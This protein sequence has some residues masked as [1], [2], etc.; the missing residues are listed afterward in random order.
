MDIFKV[1]LMVTRKYDRDQNQFEI[2]DELKTEKNSETID[3]LILITNILLYIN[4]K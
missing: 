2:C 1:L 3:F 4:N